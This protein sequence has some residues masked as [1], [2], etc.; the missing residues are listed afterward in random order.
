MTVNPIILGEIP[1]LAE[2]LARALDRPDVGERMR[3]LWRHGYEETRRLLALHG[4]AA[5]T[6]IVRGIHD[7]IDRSNRT[8]IDAAP[9]VTGRKVACGPRCSFCCYQHVM[10][11]SSEAITLAER[12]EVDDTAL[13]RDLDAYAARIDGL[14]HH[15][16]YVKTLAC[17]L[18]I[19]KTCMAYDDRPEECRSHFSLSRFHCE[20]DFRERFTRKSG[21]RRGIPMLAEPKGINPCLLLGCDWA[22]HQAGFQMCWMELTPFLAQATKPGARARWLAGETVFVPATN[23]TYVARLAEMAASI[24]G[25]AC[26]AEPV[27]IE[28]PPPPT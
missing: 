16:R 27:L 7:E 12:L 23:D 11:S 4:C 15:Q 19:S 26:A 3:A 20:K 2:A 21:E 1:P 24:M 28:D 10:V 22:L 14:T 5:V 25:S 9:T 17:P 8:Y 13:N 18:L 6:G